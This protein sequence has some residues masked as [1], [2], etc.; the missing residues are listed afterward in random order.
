M[1]SLLR[2][3]GGNRGV[4]GG[5]RRRLRSSNSS[6]PCDAA[7]AAWPCDRLRRRLGHGRS[8][9]GDGLRSRTSRRR[10]RR[11]KIGWRRQT[12]KLRSA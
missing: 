8:S 4:S 6:W 3:S 7:K 5:L 10:W 9:L 12:S 11:L 2:V 1:S